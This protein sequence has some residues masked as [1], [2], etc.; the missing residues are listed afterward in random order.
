MTIEKTISNLIESQ[1]P[2]F[3]AEEGPRFIEFVKTYYEWMEEDNVLYHSRRLLEYNDIDTTIDDFLIH[4]K[5]KYLNSIQ[6]ETVVDTRSLV[7]HSLDLYRS[8]GTERSVD[9]F[10]RSIFGE[11]ATIYYPGDDVFKTSDGM[12]VRP[13]Y[14]EL[15]VSDN[16]KEFIGV[17][18][19]GINSGATAFVEKYVKKRSADSGFYTHLYYLNSIVGE[20]E[21]GEKVR[22]KLSG[23]IG[24]IIRGS[25]NDLIVVDGSYGY[26]IGDSV[27][28]TSPK[29]GID[30]IARVTDISSVTGKV[31]FALEDGGWGYNSSSQILIAENMLTISDLVY[32][33]NNLSRFETIAQPMVNVQYQDLTGG[34][35]AVGDI[36]VKLDPSD[37]LIYSKGTVLSINATNSSAG[38][39]LLAI[40]DGKTDTEH[41]LIDE[42]GFNLI[43]EAGFNLVTDGITLTEDGYI[44]S[45]PD[46]SYE[47]G[48]LV[49]TE[50]S[51]PL[52]IDGTDYYANVISFTDVTASGN[53][54]KYSANAT[55][56]GMMTGASRFANGEFVYVLDA[57]SQN[58]G[59]G[60]IRVVSYNGSNATISIENYRG[61]FDQ[62]FTL[63]SSNSTAEANITNV[64]TDIGVINVENSFVVS[65]GNFIISLSSNATGY[66]SRI[67][68]GSSADFD[69]VNTFLYEKTVQINTDKI[70]DYPGVD[71]DVSDYGFPPPG[72][73]DGN[74]IIDDALT[75]VNV[76]VGKISGIVVT[77]DGADYDTAPYV[78]IYEPLI[79][80]FGKKDFILNIN[81]STGN[82]NIG[83][84]I[85]QDSI[86][87]GIVKSNS[88]SS[89]L[90]VQRISIDDITSTANIVGDTSGSEASLVDVVIDLTSNVAGINGI[91][92]ANTS[93]QAGSVTEFD[94][95]D[96]GFA[97]DDLENVTFVKDGLL[98]GTIKTVLSSYGTSEGYYRYNNSVLSGEKRLHDG[99][100]YQDFSYEV[101]S[102][103]QL[104]KYVDILKNVIHMA[105]T[106]VFSRFI[107]ES[108]SNVAS[109]ASTTITEE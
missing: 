53:L 36:L 92:L 98:P 61:R 62:T 67:G 85:L 78:I 42:A 105:G 84:V 83:E 13:Q 63:L 30:A 90:Y 48:N 35:V 50:D 82:F 96:S 102:S 69:L 56:E 28:I 55:I 54:I 101:N 38:Y 6:F 9:L 99:F 23:V 19:E 4:F 104:Q 71:L 58:V 43:D 87:M 103:V 31:S 72:E 21:S 34:S 2:A 24:P 40:T 60:N 32:D 80:D 76:S 45:L 37:D 91:V 106:K 79:Y 8:K 29:N 11:P 93:A 18:I 65:N 64:T 97:Y 10:F 1:F 70:Q 33:G 22:N 3:Y 108:V 57:N 46:M 75:H 27:N 26:A 100:Y 107:L 74:T 16:I 39:I 94:M 5:N 7:K 81:A 14:L 59:N 25:V 86:E 88:N 89:I 77:S 49:F 66:I 41:D 68:A 109:T 12:W 95:L 17:E 44:Y 51:S 15:F 47:D 20:F 73:E 52:H